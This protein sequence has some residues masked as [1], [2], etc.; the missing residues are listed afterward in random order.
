MCNKRVLVAIHSIQVDA[1]SRGTFQAAVQWAKV[2]AEF[3]RWGVRVMV[4]SG[5]F[6]PT[7]QVMGS[8]WSA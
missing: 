7:P 4:C 8:G 2:K 6:L 5:W 1:V 3:S